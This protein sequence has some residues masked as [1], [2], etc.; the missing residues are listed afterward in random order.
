[1][2]KKIFKYTINIVMYSFFAI[3][4]VFALLF[5]TGIKPYITISGSMEPNI[6]TGSIC[7][8]DTNEQYDDVQINDVIAFKM[9][10]TL[11]THRV[12][13]LTE[14][15]IQTKG[16]NNE[17]PDLSVVNNNNFVGKTLFS[18]PYIGYLIMSLKK[19][20]GIFLIVVVLSTLMLLNLI[21]FLL[22]KKTPR[23]NQ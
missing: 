9:N 22:A 11:V 10:N 17:D 18:I 4:L 2:A 7:F 15:G 3:A 20:I 13:K 16:D 19:P 14:N 1:M 23:S 12:I 5:I 8:I 6:Q 21:D